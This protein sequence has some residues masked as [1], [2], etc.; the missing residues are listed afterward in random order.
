MNARHLGNALIACALLVGEFAWSNEGMV[1]VG[2]TARGP[3]P[4]FVIR[5]TEIACT[6][7]QSPGPQLPIGCA[8]D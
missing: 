5:K 4:D 6:T 8:I 1:P 2:E 3:I 7:E